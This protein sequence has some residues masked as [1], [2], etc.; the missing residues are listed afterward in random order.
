MK[1]VIKDNNA[2]E[3]WVPHKYQ[4]KAADFLIKNKEAALFLDP[5][6][7]KTAITLNAILQLK[8]KKVIKKVLII[9][10]LLVCY[11]VWPA[12]I[13]KW[14]QFNNLSVAIAHG[15]KKL[16]ALD[17]DADITLI[18]YE[19]I[20]WLFSLKGGG[21]NTVNKIKKAGFDVLV[22][23]ELSKMKNA[24]SNRFKVLKNLLNAFKFRWGL[25]G[26][27]A[28]NGLMDLFGEC[29][30]LDN[31][32]A[33]GRYITHFKHAYF[34]TVDPKGLIWRPLKDSADKIFDK[35]KHL[36]LRMKAEDYLDMPEI[37]Y[38]NI[39]VDLD[40]KT[41]AIYDEME[42]EFITAINDKIVTAANAAVVGGKCRQ[43]CS[44]AIYVRD[45][46]DDIDSSMYEIIHTAKIE[47]LLNLI[48]ELQG[49]QLLVAYEFIHEKYR[50]ADALKSYKAE[51]IK[52]K[53]AVTKSIVDAWNK[54]LINILLGQP[55]SMGH[56][57]N[58]QGSNCA[59]VCWFTPT[60]NFELYDQFNRR[61]Y[62]QGNNASKIV[63]HSII[64]K[65]TIDMV[66]QQ[67]LKSKDM[68]QNNLFNALVEYANSKKILKK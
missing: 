45:M 8:K 56:G 5:G 20:A 46:P 51:F 9:A 19:A 54:G 57:L 23:D 34:I 37:I 11:N 53:S 44:G 66:V 67:A 15:R 31:G 4:K 59:H 38:N 2:A 50:L 68:Q 32:K 7:G 60:W 40:K 28:A 64:V 10:P 6:L 58:L 25:T 13:K 12:E 24:S 35:I 30:M 17:T 26:S 52:P 42:K 27:P 61:I 47:A 55:Q 33:L 16:E 3:Q 41:R 18:N 21:L 39:Y 43:I 48:E 63:V 62:R 36:A 49:N 1:K 14:A 65:D 29:F 22:F